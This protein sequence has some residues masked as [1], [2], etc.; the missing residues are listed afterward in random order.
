MFRLSLNVI[1]NLSAYYKLAECAGGFKS[2]TDEL[3]AADSV[4][5][6]VLS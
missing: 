4:D 5:S 2:I 3:D 6:F 1:P